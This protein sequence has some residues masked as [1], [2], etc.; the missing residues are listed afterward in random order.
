MFDNDPDP[1]IL[2]QIRQ[3][4]AQDIRHSSS[5]DELRQR[6]AGK[7]VTPAASERMQL[8]HAVDTGSIA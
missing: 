8:P 6:L 7:G 5:S 2:S 1:Q 4:I 3:L